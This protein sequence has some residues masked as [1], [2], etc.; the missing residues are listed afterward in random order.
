MNGRTDRTVEKKLIYNNKDVPTHQVH[1]KEGNNWS[2][3]TSQEV[4]AFYRSSLGAK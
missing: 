1:Y 3:V 2:K 4:L